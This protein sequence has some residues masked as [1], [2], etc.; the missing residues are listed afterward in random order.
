MKNPDDTLNDVPNAC[1]VKSA[2]SSQTGAR[3]RQAAANLMDR[4]FLW[5]GAMSMSESASNAITGFGYED[6]RA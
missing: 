5:T 3:R 2:S 1:H 4:Q 6:H